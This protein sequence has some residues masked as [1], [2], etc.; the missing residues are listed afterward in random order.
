MLTRFK[1]TGAEEEDDLKPFLRRA[2]LMSYPYIFDKERDV[3]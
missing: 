3:L 1:V 2:F